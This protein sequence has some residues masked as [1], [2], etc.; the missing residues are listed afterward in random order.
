MAHAIV[1]TDKMAGTDVRTKL[2]SVLYQNASGKAQEIDNGNVVVIDGLM[3]GEREIYKAVTPAVSSKLGKIVLIASPEVMYDER[4]KN[5]S[6]FYNDGSVPQ[7]G[8]VLT[9]G[10]IFTV[11]AP[12]VGNVVEMAAGTK[13]NIAASATSG[14][15]QIGKIIEV[16]TLHGETGY[17]IQVD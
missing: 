13:L 6:D 2:V 10:D 5:Y 15:T 3:S 8:Y 7:R 12:A 14:S 17:T 1:N 9:S 11:S 4:L 16:G